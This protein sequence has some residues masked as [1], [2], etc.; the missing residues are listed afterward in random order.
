MNKLLR[1]TLC[2]GLVLLSTQLNAAI[3]Q[4]ISYQGYLTNS[5]GTP[6]SGTVAITFR[7]YNAASGGA[8]LYT[9]AQPAVTVNVGAFNAGWWAR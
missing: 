6:I 9:E 2:A 4:T 7:L 1:F 5:G 3:P 8:A